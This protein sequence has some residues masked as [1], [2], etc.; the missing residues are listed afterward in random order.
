MARVVDDQFF[1][2]RLRLDTNSHGR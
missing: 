1:S 2:E